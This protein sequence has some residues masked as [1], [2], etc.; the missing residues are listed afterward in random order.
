MPL[1]HDNED[2]CNIVPDVAKLCVV[3]IVQL[4]DG[5][6]HLIKLASDPL[7]GGSHCPTY[8][9]ASRV[10]YSVVFVIEPCLAI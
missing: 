7:K 3:K 9:P 2:V 6:Y 8:N 4:I 10:V 1:R 5:S